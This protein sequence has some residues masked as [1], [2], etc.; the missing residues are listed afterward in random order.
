MAQNAVGFIEAEGYTAIVDA[1]D[2]MAKSTEVVV[3]GMTRLGGGIVAVAIRGDL[4][5]VD[6]AA[7]IGEEAARA[8][9]RAVRSIVFASPC[10]AVA[11][12][13]DDLSV[14]GS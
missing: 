10:D 2:A 13:A 14:V 12:L 8:R 4:A 9:T 1:V 5:T 3:A 11:E 6:E 7:R